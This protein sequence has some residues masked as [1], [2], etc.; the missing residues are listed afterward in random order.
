MADGINANRVQISSSINVTADMGKFWAGKA[1]EWATSGDIVDTTD[2]SA[3]Y[4]ATN[5]KNYVTEAAQKLDTV[6]ADI[7][8]FENNLNSEIAKVE[9]VVEDNLETIETA[10]SESK[11]WANKLDDTVDGEEYSAKYYAQQASETVSQALTEIE[12]AQN[13]AVSNIEDTKE[14]AIKNINEAETSAV[15]TIDKGLQDIETARKEA[16]EDITGDIDLEN[17]YSKEE[18]DDLLAQKA[19]IFN[20][21]NPITNSSSVING[22]ANG[23][24]KDGVYTATVA[25]TDNKYW[26]AGFS[27]S[28]ISKNAYSMTKNGANYNSYIAIP[29]QIPANTYSNVFYGSWY[30]GYNNNSVPSAVYYPIFGYAA[31]TSSNS[32]YISYSG[33]SGLICNPDSYDLDTNNIIIK[34]SSNTDKF[35]ASSKI[36]A[37]I[38]SSFATTGTFDYTNNTYWRIKVSEMKVGGTVYLQY[39]TTKEQVNWITVSKTITQDIIDGLQRVNIAFYPVRNK[40]IEVGKTY[41]IAPIYAEDLETKMELA[42]NTI[43][44]NNLGLNLSSVEDNILMVKDDGLYAP[45]TG[46]NK[47]D[48]IS[49]THS[50]MYWYDNK[51]YLALEN[52][53]GLLSVNITDCDP[54]ASSPEMSQINVNVEGLKEE[55]LN[56]LTIMRI[57]QS[58]YDAL[59][60]KDVNVM[61]VVVE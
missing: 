19:N 16:L 56:G 3:K 58:D 17:Y 10:V 5:A 49:G 32:A 11:D 4:Y 12:G 20:V 38:S 30:L 7:T 18:T 15:N 59:A 21:S 2:Y 60:T 50:G 22:V 40:S 61:Y 57:S 41:D 23:T 6:S 31:K 13:T 43:I 29:F 24:Y 8:H 36:T 27:V 39:K 45:D 25:S 53:D 34:Q 26:N 33:V 1:Q 55:I 51:M 48:T 42:A 52:T 28:D 54:T 9:T 37:T 14:N 47:Q 44:T 46:T 35:I